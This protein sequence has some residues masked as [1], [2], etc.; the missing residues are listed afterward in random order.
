MAASSNCRE[1]QLRFSATAAVIGGFLMGA[2]WIWQ[3]YLDLT[4]GADAILHDTN[5]I[6]YYLN[7][8]MLLLSSWFLLHGL[9]AFRYQN[10]SAGG[11]V[12]KIGFFLTALGLGLFGIGTAGFLF[13]GL[14]GFGSLI[15]II[16]ISTGIGSLAI[17]LG[18]LPLG[19]TIL[20]HT[21]TPRYS[22]LLFILQTPIVIVY[23]FGIMAINPLLAGILIG[24][25][26]GGA[27]VIIGFYL[28][29]YA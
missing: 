2:N 19:F 28:R 5:H 16:N 6:A 11:W 26:Y 20:H 9:F 23:L 7:N 1:S 22:S 17:H 12:W 13:H 24:G 3:G 27:W 14:I 8:L 18:A 21:S 10:P 15:D 4:A 29:R 25:M